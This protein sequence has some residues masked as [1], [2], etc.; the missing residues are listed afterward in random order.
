MKLYIVWA[1]NTSYSHTIFHHTAHI[2]WAQEAAFIN[3]GFHN[4]AHNVWAQSVAYSHTIFTKVD[5]V[6]LMQLRSII[7]M[8]TSARTLYIVWAQGASY[9]HAVSQDTAH[10]AGRRKML[11]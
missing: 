2:C 11:S 7:S 5:T 6:I 3:G 9:N 10:I 8:V 4:T 1:Q